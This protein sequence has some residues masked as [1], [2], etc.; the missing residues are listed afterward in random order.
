ML[1]NTVIKVAKILFC[2]DT[3]NF[4][5]GP[6]YYSWVTTGDELLTGSTERGSVIYDLNKNDAKVT[7]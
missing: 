3:P 1:K 5:D 2:V 6:T 4:L 7:E